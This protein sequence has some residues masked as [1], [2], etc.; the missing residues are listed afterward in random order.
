MKTLKK[1]STAFFFIL[2][3]LVYVQVQAQ[4]AVAFYDKTEGIFKQNGGNLYIFVKKHQENDRYGNSSQG[5]Q[6]RSA[7]NATPV[8]Y[9][10][11]V[12]NKPNLYVMKGNKS[13]KYNFTSNNTL[14]F[15]FPGSS[16]TFTRVST[17]TE[18]FKVDGNDVM[19]KVQ[20]APNQ[21]GVKFAFQ[22]SA[23]ITWWKGIKV[24]NTNLYK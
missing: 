20:L 2:F 6:V 4:P 12:A 24:F 10:R 8:Y 15:H 3:S 9:I 22:K 13:F 11:S 7:T 19:L 21:R 14:T 5:I 1:L 16:A 17:Y 18:R 23:R